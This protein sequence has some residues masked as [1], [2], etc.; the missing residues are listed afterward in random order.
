MFGFVKT[1]L[2]AFLILLALSLAP[3]TVQAAVLEVNTLRDD[4]V[5]SLRDALLQANASHEK[6]YV[7]FKIE[8]KN[9]E[10]E[11]IIYVDAPLPDITANHPVIIEGNEN[12]ILDGSKSK[13]R[14]PGLVLRSSGHRLSKL[15]I[16]NF[17]GGGILVHG[18]DEQNIEDIHIFDN[19][20]LDNGIFDENGNSGDGIRLAVNVRN[21]S[22]H[23]NLI[24]RNRGNGIHLQSLTSAV[25]Q[26]RIFGNFVTANQ[27]NGIRLEGSRNTLGIN[28][29]QMP[30]PNVITQNN[31]HGLLVNG[32]FAHGN[33][34]AYDYI[35]IG[36]EKNGL[37]NRLDGIHLKAGAKNNRLGP[38]LKVYY[39]GGG[40][41]I[42]DPQ[43]LGNEITDSEI[44]ANI[45]E[46]IYIENVV[47]EPALKIQNN[48]VSQNHLDGIHINGASPNVWSNHVSENARYGIYLTPYDFD[49]PDIFEQTEL[50]YSTPDISDNRIERNRQGGLYALDTIFQDWDKVEEQ[51]EFFKNTDYDALVQWYHV[52]GF[53]PTSNDFG[54]LKVEISA[55]TPDK[56]VCSGNEIRE[57]DDG[58]Y[59]GPNSLF[60]QKE[61][62]S[63]FKVTHFVVK[64]KTRAD[65]S[66]HKITVTGDQEK[67]FYLSDRERARKVLDDNIPL[68]AQSFTD[69]EVEG[70][71]HLTHFG[72]FGI[73][74]RHSQ[75]FWGIIALVIVF[76]LYH[77]WLA[78]HRIKRRDRL[79]HGGLEKVVAKAKP[80]KAPKKKAKK[81]A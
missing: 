29:D 14:F 65:Y 74:V 1:F 57:G 10:G 56:K 42:K 47:S 32:D 31:L 55:C 2:G 67:G 26:N 28:A 38:G 20:V 49:N 44:V 36:P 19:H 33:H 45:N 40:I 53:D 64:N 81:K 63:F 43:S 35:G 76:F 13:S 6:S 34:V 51:N 79:F 46:G 3:Q 77:F 66:P 61:R 22:V 7:V 68:S 16:Q 18:S 27:K 80:K 73:V 12:L 62:N 15:T 24:A 25:W 50:L 11:S 5:G 70:P 37:G 75:W 21:C 69:E 23:D 8:E 9:E 78:G 52:F 60:N 72:N 71:V 30:S 41:V 4:G 48:L 39:N 17:G 58:F 54:A 59:V